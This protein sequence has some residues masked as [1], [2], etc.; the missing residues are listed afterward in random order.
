MVHGFL[1][2]VGVGR[3]AKSYVAEIA[4]PTP[5]LPSPDRPHTRS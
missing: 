5:Q 3:E 4:E 1:H 2:L